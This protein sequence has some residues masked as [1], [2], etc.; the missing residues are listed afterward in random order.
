M[1]PQSIPCF[2]PA[3][4]IHFCLIASAE[5]QVSYDLS[6]RWQGSLPCALDATEG[7]GSGNPALVLRLDLLSESEVVISIAVTMLLKEM[8][9][10][11]QL[12]NLLTPL[13]QL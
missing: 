11:T 1:T 3:Y 6:Q 12:A 10:V 7:D 4:C 13:V 2:Y 9:S 5:C 8:A